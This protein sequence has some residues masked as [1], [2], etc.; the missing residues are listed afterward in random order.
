[1]AHLVDG[2]KAYTVVFPDG[3]GFNPSYRLAKSPSYPGI[4]N[5]YRRTHHALEMLKPDI[6]LAQHNEYYDLEGKRDRALREGV[7]AW[8]DPEG[9]RRF[10]ASKKRAFEDQV[11]L[12]LSGPAQPA[13]R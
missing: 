10:V 4:E 3:G 11:D 8:I 6:G 7:R 9:Y 13:Q 12:E 1:M 5:D 2:G